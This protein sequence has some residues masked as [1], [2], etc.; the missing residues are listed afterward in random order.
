MELLYILLLLLNVYCINVG[1]R[2]V[3]LQG[4][5][6]IAMVEQLR[7]ESKVCGRDFSKWIGCG[8]RRDGEVNV[9]V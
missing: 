5:G 9:N 7:K 2:F 6:V 1:V 4:E 3:G 8:K